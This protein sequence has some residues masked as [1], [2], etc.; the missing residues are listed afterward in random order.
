MASPPAPHQLQCKSQLSSSSMRHLRL[1]CC[2][3]SWSF[4]HRLLAVLGTALHRLLR[5][6]Q[7][8]NWTEALGE[9]LG[10]VGKVLRRSS[11]HLGYF[12]GGDALWRCSFG[13]KLR[14]VC[15]ASGT[16]QEAA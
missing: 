1:A 14:H 9:V 16:A 12:D 7:R 5:D 15:R 11:P 10:I 2:S 13:A 8:V 3:L 4:P 6:Q